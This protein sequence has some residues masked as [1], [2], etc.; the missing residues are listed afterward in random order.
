M[1]SLDSFPEAPQAQ[2]LLKDLKNNLPL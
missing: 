1:H 2:S